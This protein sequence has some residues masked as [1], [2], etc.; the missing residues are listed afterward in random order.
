MVFL[1]ILLPQGW[2]RVLMSSEGPCPG[3]GLPG[4]SWVWHSRCWGRGLAASDS[5]LPSVLE[6]CIPTARLGRCSDGL[7]VETVAS[8]E[9]PHL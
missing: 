7:D 9:A 2:A 8:L 5:F 1:S 6:A 3:L 4:G